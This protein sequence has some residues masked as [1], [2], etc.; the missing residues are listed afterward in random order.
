M[1]DFIKENK[2]MEIEEEE[3]EEEINKTLIKKNQSKLIPIKDRLTSRFLTK[4]EK[5]KVIGERAIQISNGEEVYIDIPEGIWD[6][7]L[8]AEIE[9]KQRKI[10][11]IIRRY[12][13]DGEF[14]E[15]QVT[16]LHANVMREL[17]KIKCPNG[18]ETHEFKQYADVARNGTIVFVIM[19]EQVSIIS[20]CKLTEKQAATQR[21][22]ICEANGYF[23]L[24]AY[25]FGEGF[26]QKINS[27]YM[28]ERGTY[29]TWVRR[30]CHIER[31]NQTYR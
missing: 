7:L 17:Y 19:G 2:E 8:I 11:F 15:F 29:L 5:A 6:P 23:E 16:G 28:M 20:P 31:T 27:G 10:P 3:E 25:L 22:K 14:E 12:L 9:L 4:Y 13:P 21:Q 18:T 26:A 1:N 30:L 24:Y